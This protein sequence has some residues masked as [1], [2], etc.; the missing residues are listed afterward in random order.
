M[1]AYSEQFWIGVAFVRAAPYSKQ[2]FVLLTS[3][4]RYIRRI[5]LGVFRYFR[6]V[7]IRG[8]CQRD[9]L[10][11]NRSARFLLSWEQILF[12]SENL[13]R[14]G[15]RQMFCQR[16]PRFPRQSVILSLTARL[17]RGARFGGP[18]PTPPLHAWISVWAY[19]FASINTSPSATTIPSSSSKPISAPCFPPPL[20]FWI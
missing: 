15:E 12:L 4:L 3:E 11:S 5:Y 16:S 13:F 1:T 7:L 20:L 2:S 8:S 10:P 9:L 17:L 14:Q 19:P 18:K 6:A